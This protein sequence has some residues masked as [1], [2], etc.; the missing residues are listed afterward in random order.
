M[1]KLLV[2]IFIMFSMSGLSQ[3]KILV[4]KLDVQGVIKHLV[5]DN[6]ESYIP[7]EKAK[8][9]LRDSLKLLK[10]DELILIKEIVDELGFTHQT[11][12]QHY[13]GIKI[14]DGQYGVCARN[15]KIENIGGEFKIVRNVNLIASISKKEA[16]GKALD[17]IKAT[18]YSWQIPSLE[19]DLK[20]NSKDSIGTFYP[21]GEIVVC[22]DVIKTNS[23][24]RLAFKFKIAAVEPLSDKIYYID[25][26]TGDL[27]DIRDLIF[28]TN[29]PATAATLYSGSSVNIET[30]W[31]YQ[32]SKYKL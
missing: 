9:L 22:K 7:L 19:S 14:E 27:L 4:K 30:V 23:I 5:F 21:N 15:G 28:D 6:S 8:Q 13:N 25:A 16:L 32:L 24:Y 2:F 18:K 29:T 1:K 20:T 11:Y 12:E 10:E 3:Q 17:Y 31:D 26:I